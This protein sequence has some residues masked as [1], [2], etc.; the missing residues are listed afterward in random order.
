MFQVILKQVWRDSRW[1]L[2]FLGACA[3]VITQGVV[4]VTHGLPDNDMYGAVLV[5]AQFWGLMMPVLAFFAALL[6][7]II[8]WWPDR[9]G[10]WVYALTLPIERARYALMRAAAGGVMLGALALL[11]WVA[12]IVAT[13]QAVVPDG[14]HF[15]AGTIALRFALALLVCHALWT[16]LSLTGR[17]AAWAVV[18][19]VVVSIGC[20]LLGI[21]AVSWVVNALTGQWSPLHILGGRW[22]LIDA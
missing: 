10:W 20:E 1:M 21:H 22:M 18:G 13:S 17:P 14:L 9:R 12:A 2:L 5:E 4:R 6:L 19:I 15:Y 8:T 7:A 11:F 16:M 3:V